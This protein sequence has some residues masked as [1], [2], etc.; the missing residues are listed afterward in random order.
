MLSNL[1]EWEEMDLIG[2]CTSRHFPLFSSLFCVPVSVAKANQADEKQESAEKPE[3]SEKLL[4]LVV[5][6]P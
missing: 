2:E 3:I 5:T 6:Q 1:L 4:I